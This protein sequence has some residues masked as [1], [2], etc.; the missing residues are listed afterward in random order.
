MLRRLLLVLSVFTTCLS[1]LSAGQDA[2]AS[3]G[4]RGPR[5]LVASKG[6]KPPVAIDI[7]RTPVLSRRVS[8]ELDNVPLDQALKRVA[9]LGG[10]TLSY[11]TAVIPFDRLVRLKAADITVAAALTEVL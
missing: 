3:Q 8:V 9:A 6:S 10:F 5:F 2:G 7:A 4:G 11:S 1:A